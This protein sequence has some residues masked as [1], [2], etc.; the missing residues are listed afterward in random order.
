M[1]RYCLIL[2]LLLQGWLIE[3]SKQRDMPFFNS[4]AGGPSMY[5][6]YVAALYFTLSSLTSVGFGNISANT[7]AEKIFCICTMFVGGMGLCSARQSKKFS[8]NADVRPGVQ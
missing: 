4:T 7:P 5:S 3:L 6:S 2:Y 1:N 8:R